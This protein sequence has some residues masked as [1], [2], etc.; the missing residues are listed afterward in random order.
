L[1][2]GKAI[3]AA[4]EPA[5]Q[6]GFCNY[7]G[8]KAPASFSYV[9]MTNGNIARLLN[10][11]RRGATEFGIAGQLTVLFDGQAVNPGS[12]ETP[13]ARRRRK[14]HQLRGRQ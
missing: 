11:R 14:V 1:K 4:V 6:A 3:N 9:R 5:D 2:G 8:L 7:Y 10:E 13:T 12:Y